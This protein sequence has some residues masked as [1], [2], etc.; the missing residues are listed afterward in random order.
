MLR[1]DGD[2]GLP[3][4]LQYE[5]GPNEKGTVTNVTL[6]GYPGCLQRGDYPYATLDTMEIGLEDGNVYEHFV[7]ICGGNSGGP[8][9]VKSTSKAFAINVA[10]RLQ[11][12]GSQR[13]PVCPTPPQLWATTS[14][15]RTCSA[16]YDEKTKLVHH[17]AVDRIVHCNT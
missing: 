9:L 17:E 6:L 3:Q 12:V 10:E 5:T 8:A 4:Y 11:V 2:L 14:R 16:S 15:L 13:I 1:V 7:D